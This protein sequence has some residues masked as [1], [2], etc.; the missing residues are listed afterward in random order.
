MSNFNLEVLRQ[1]RNDLLLAEVAAWLHDMGKCSDEHVTH[2]ASDCPSRH[3]YQYKRAQSYLL[4]AS[5]PPVS[6][7]GDAVSVKDLIEKGMPKAISQQSEPWI[8][9]VLGRCHSVAHV[10]KELD[11][12]DKS[13]KQRKSD[14]R[15]SSAF[16][17]EGPPVSGLT[18]LLNGLPFGSL[19][20]Y[21]A[22]I[23][24]VKD[25]FARAIGDTR[26]PVNEVTLTDW[27]ATVSCSYKSALAG[28]LLGTQP[29]P[30]DLRW[31]LLRI[32]F[33]VLGLY[34]KAIKIADLLAY[35]DVVRGACEA[36]KR[37]VEDE[38]PLGNEVYRDTTGV[39]FTFPDLDLWPE[40]RD[41]LRKT[42][43][44]VEGELMPRIAV[45][46]APGQTATEQLARILHH[47]RSEARKALAYPVDP[48]NDSLCWQ[49][50]WSN[51]PSKSEVCPVCRLRPMPEG[52]ET[53]E[54]CWNRRQSRIEA[55][56]NNPA[57]TIWLDEIADHN[58][59]I[60]L[61]VG[62]FDL[63]K[64]LSGDLVQTMLVQAKQND[65]EGCKPKNPSPARLRRVWETC[66]RFW[67]DT[68]ENTILEQY[69]YA[70]DRSDV[71]LRCSR[72]FV[73]PDHKAVWRENVPYD[74][75]IG[76][77]P[78]SL[79]W[80]NN[81][82]HFVT[83]INLQLA[84]GGAKT[85]QEVQDKWSGQG[86]E[87][88]DPD[89]PRKRIQ[90]KIDAVAR[91]TDSWEQYRPYLTLLTSPDQFLAFIP[92]SES[93]A[94]AERI[95]QEYQRQ[96][97]KVQNRLP[98]FL[99]LVFFQHKTPLMAVMDTARRMLKQLPIPMHEETW[100][101]ECSRQG[102]PNWHLRLSRGEQRVSLDVPVTMGD[103]TTEDAWYPYFF[104]ENG[105]NINGRLYR[106]QHN[107]G[108]WLVHVKDLHEGDRIS[109]TPSRFAYLFLEHTAQRFRFNPDRDVSLLDE[110]P[111]LIEMWERLHQSGMTD[112]D[113]RSVAAILETKAEMWGCES[114]EF[115]HLTETTLKVS[116]LW[117]RKDKPDT[118]TPEEVLSGRF[119][120]C[121]ELYLRILKA[122]LKKE[123]DHER[124][125]A[126]V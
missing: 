113:L 46:S 48:E 96:F 26:R 59:R 10:E 115:L 100:T 61:L 17:I 102:N 107:D 9:R 3:Q 57:Q 45:G 73:T 84:A 116:G 40:L 19:T 104:V 2:Q 41:L 50:Q 24:A 72:L 105:V 51:A 95:R 117:Q 92:A 120:R 118:V 112:T 75:T 80:R 27:S 38:Y 97:G 109:I 20:N 68:V 23:A 78:I 54:H 89:N 16:G 99:G 71:A 1:H 101:V 29:D 18:S 69:Q 76:G 7:L 35:Q 67:A 81:E 79:L 6:L 55:W 28:A 25:A 77:Q 60:A 47:E 123:N 74:G 122:R 88:S 93:L 62:K 64:W 86:I 114:Q 91:A 39:Y 90:F 70:N 32:N 21:N 94:I 5:I 12:N 119:S 125:P 49:Q 83:I 34:A 82:K 124:Q 42:V 66:Q 56:K 106:F 65:P 98:L 58:D 33:D 111:L 13:T 14:T 37:L 103:G 30:D 110:L 43:E 63:E 53:C 8:L 108:R 22:F 44:G 126:T 11:D 15:L 4:P 36:V 87:V 121:L 52:E 85:L 31:R